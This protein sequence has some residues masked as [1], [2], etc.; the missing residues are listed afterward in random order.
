MADNNL[1]DAFV[2]IQNFKALY[3]DSNKFFNIF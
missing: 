2:L 3:F 1:K